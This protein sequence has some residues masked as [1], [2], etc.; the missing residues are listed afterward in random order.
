MT[1]NAG[2]REHFKEI[3]LGFSAS[4][5]ERPNQEEESRSRVNKAL[6][7]TFRPIVEPT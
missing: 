2:G 1:S 4:D 6:K 5:E 3:S 7:A